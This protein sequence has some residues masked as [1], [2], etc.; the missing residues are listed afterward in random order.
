M[1]FTDPGGPCA[2]ALRATQTSWRDAA[3]AAAAGAPGTGNFPEFS[4]ASKGDF[5]PRAAGVEN[6]STFSE[7]CQTFLFFSGTGRVFRRIREAPFQDQGMF[8]RE[9]GKTR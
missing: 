3:P 5:P 1:Q 4:H 2:R 8:H 6:L 7:T 9:Q